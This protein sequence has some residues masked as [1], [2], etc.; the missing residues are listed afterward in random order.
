MKEGA[1]TLKVAAKLVPAIFVIQIPQVWRSPRAPTM[2]PSLSSHLLTLTPFLPQT[3]SKSF[4]LCLKWRASASPAAPG[5]DLTTLET[6]I[7]KVMHFF[8]V[9]GLQK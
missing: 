5:V 1:T 6:A 7:A 3:P 4:G 2:N 8:N 9:L